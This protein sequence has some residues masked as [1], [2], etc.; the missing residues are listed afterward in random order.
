MGAPCIPGAGSTASSR[1]GSGMTVGHMRIPVSH[2]SSERSADNE[3]Y[4][5]GCDLVVAAAGIRQVAGSLDAAR[6]VPAVLGCIEAAL[7]ELA[8]ATA[9]LEKT[10]GAASTAYRPSATRAGRMHRGY[11]NLRQALADAE[12]AAT[13]AR[14]L[15]GRVL[16][17]AGT[18]RHETRRR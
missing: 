6:A 16:A 7:H 11:A 1:K 13:A 12:H 15:V 10:T 5:L 18:A 14:A 2:R 4:D 3:L 9:G 17:Q 8:E